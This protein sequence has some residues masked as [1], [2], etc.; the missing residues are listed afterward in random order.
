MFV[1]L[2][3][4]DAPFKGI[5]FETMGVTFKQAKDEPFSFVLINSPELYRFGKEGSDRLSF[6]DHFDRPGGARD[7]VSFYNLGKDARLVVPR[8]VMR[9]N[10]GPYCHLAKFVREAPNKQV[11]AV[12]AMVGQEYLRE[13]QKVPS[14]PIWLST[15]GLGVAWLHFRLDTSPKYYQYRLFAKGIASSARSERR[16]NGKK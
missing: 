12:F 2:Q 11:D 4:Q 16:R 14:R 6:A 8:P 5:F 13:L 15:S 1:L 3:R 10:Y 7:A 9:D